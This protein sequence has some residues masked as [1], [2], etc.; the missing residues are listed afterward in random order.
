MLPDTDLSPP[1]VCQQVARPSLVSD[2]REIGVCTGFLFVVCLFFPVC[3]APEG[4]LLS[5]SV[6]GK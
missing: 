3:D 4:G 5:F 2:G 6:R 1:E